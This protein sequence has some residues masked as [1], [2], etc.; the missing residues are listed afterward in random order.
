MKHKISG[1][2]SKIRYGAW[3][4]DVRE[5]VLNYLVLLMEL[6]FDKVMFY[7]ASLNKG[8]IIEKYLQDFNHLLDSYRVILPDT[9]EKLF[10]T[11]L[12]MLKFMKVFFLWK[13]SS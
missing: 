4:I 6:E 10:K 8:N 13:E 9:I 5:H 11:L 3:Q 12:A 2:P 7:F 1:V